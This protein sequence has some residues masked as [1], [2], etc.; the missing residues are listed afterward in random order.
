MVGAVAKVC[1]AKARGE[2]V[3]SDDAPEVRARI[4]AYRKQTESLYYRSRS[5]L[6]TVDGMAAIEDVAKAIERALDGTR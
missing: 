6:R 2:A 5:V 1:R 4:G 3:R